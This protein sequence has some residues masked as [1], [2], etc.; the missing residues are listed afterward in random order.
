MQ[1]A[2]LE[3]A[4]RAAGQTQLS[5]PVIRVSAG[6][7][8]VM[9]LT[10]GASSFAASPLQESSLRVPISFSAAFS[11]PSLRL[12]LDPGS[13]QPAFDPAWERYLDELAASS[14]MRVEV[15]AAKRLWLTLCDRLGRRP[16]L[17]VTMP[18]HDRAIHLAWDAGKEYVD[19]DVTKAG[20]LWFYRNRVTGAVAGTDDAPVPTPPNELIVLLHAVA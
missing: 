11:P 10:V 5:K 15:S 18:T 17:P 8:A 12:E 13:I 6:A 2:A 20:L 19:I 3:A 9:T 14:D 7:M 4:R 1:A 16:S